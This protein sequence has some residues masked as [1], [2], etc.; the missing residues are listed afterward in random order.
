MSWTPN[1]TKSSVSENAVPAD[2]NIRTVNEL[3]AVTLVDME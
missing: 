1:M 3:S 2:M